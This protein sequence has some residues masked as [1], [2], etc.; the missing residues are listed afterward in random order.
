LAGE[1][2]GEV[3]VVV[4]EGGGAGGAGGKTHIKAKHQE[5]KDNEE[6]QTS[7][8]PV[9][10]ASCTTSATLEPSASRVAS[11]MQ[12]MMEFGFAMCCWHMARMLVLVDA[13]MPC[14]WC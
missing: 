5:K 1:R 8:T 12:R 3:V 11:W 9:G 7:D 13:A 4:G 2:E 10:S 14:V 6:N